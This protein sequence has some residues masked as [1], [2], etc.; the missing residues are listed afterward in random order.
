MN[1][2]TER[3]VHEFS[4]KQRKEMQ[5]LG[6][7]DIDSFD[8]TGAVLRTTEGIMTVEG[9][10]LKIGVLD[11][12][13]GIVTVSGKI[14]AVFYSGDNTEEKRGIISRLFRQ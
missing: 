11:T 12:E 13:R 14:N 3:S 4:V 6:V 5:V 1:G 2:Q 8:E 9:N 7:K 10:E